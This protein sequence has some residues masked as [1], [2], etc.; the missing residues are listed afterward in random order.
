MISRDTCDPTIRKKHSTLD[1]FVALLNDH[2]LIS[3]T[4]FYCFR[5]DN[6]SLVFCLSP[7]STCFP[8]IKS[9][10]WRS[11]RILRNDTSNFI[12]VLLHL[13]HEVLVHVLICWR[14]PWN[15]KR[16]F[17]RKFRT[18]GY[19]SISSLQSGWILGLLRELS[20]NSRVCTASVSPEFSLAQLWL[21]ILSSE[22]PLMEFLSAL[23]RRV[24]FINCQQRDAVSWIFSWTPKVCFTWST[25]KRR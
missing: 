19:L 22:L 4:G 24:F 23:V 13:I 20:Q 17:G 8:I 25:K 15:V 11:V 10:N 16:F 14:C 3:C 12:K 6:T 2:E 21:G 7:V 1:S 5:R 18:K 9:P